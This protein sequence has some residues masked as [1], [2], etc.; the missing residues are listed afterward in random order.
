MKNKKAIKYI[1]DT[2]PFYVHFKKHFCPKCGT[3]L[4]LQYISK[5]VNSKSQEAKN[6]DFSI[7]D[8]YFIGDVEFRTRYFYCSKCQLNFSFQEM[9]CYEKN[10][11]L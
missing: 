11:K 3:K 4:K 5:I 1:Y 8:T 6:Y 10:R 2:N 9:K 7:G